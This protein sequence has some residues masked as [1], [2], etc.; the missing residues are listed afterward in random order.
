[1]GF[2]IPSPLE[3]TGL[4]KAGES[5]TGK[6][7]HFVTHST[8]ADLTVL[9]S[10]LGEFAIGVLRNAPAS[11]EIA[12]VQHEG[13]ALV[14]VGTG[15]VVRGDRVKSNA[16]GEAIAAAAGT[17]NTSDA[18]AAADPLIGSNVNG[19][20]LRTAAAGVLVEVLLCRSGAVPTTA[21]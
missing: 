19:V 9:F 18:G 21:A 17:T 11:G 15:G 5:L 7:N 14:K 4:L 2:E 20:A 16:L 6:Q 1:M 12:E 10:R 3:P 8:A 13:I